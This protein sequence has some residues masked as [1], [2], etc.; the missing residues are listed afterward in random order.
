MHPAYAQTLTDPGA[1]GNTLLNNAIGNGGITGVFVNTL[2]SPQDVFSVGKDF[3]KDVS[4]L[5]VHIQEIAPNLP[6]GTRNVME[7]FQS[8]NSQII[9][10]ISHLQKAA[11]IANAS[12][13]ERKQ[14]LWDGA[15]SQYAGSLASAIGAA[16][17]T[18]AAAAGASAGL[19]TI[20]GVAAGAGIGAAAAI[21]FYALNSKIEWLQRP[22]TERDLG[23]RRIGNQMCRVTATTRLPRQFTCAIRS[24]RP[25]DPKSVAFSVCNDIH[26]SCTNIPDPQRVWEPEDTNPSAR[27][28]NNGGI[29]PA[30]DT[31]ETKE[32]DKS[33]AT[34]ETG[35]RLFEMANSALA[36]ADED[37]NFNK[38][39]SA[40]AAFIANGYDAQAYI[41]QELVAALVLSYMLQEIYREFSSDDDFE[42]KLYRMFDDPQTIPGRVFV[43]ELMRLHAA[44][45]EIL[46]A[47]IEAQIQSEISEMIDLQNAA[48]NVIEARE[49]EPFENQRVALLASCEAKQVALENKQIEDIVGKERET[50]NEIMRNYRSDRSELGRECRIAQA[51]INK[52]ERLSLSVR[53]SPVK[54]LQRQELINFR[55]AKKHE[56]SQ[57]LA[58]Y[59]RQSP[60]S[61][62]AQAAAENEG[63]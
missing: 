26:R 21:Y 61:L 38:T 34:D 40:T 14:M 51:E 39:M 46:E 4:D 48:L 27:T 16:T 25:D 60:K 11:E 22:A 20:A 15:Q 17:T 45:R 3:T 50:A 10:P 23:L 36:K 5:M 9:A 32:W 13:S 63:Q 47:D 59:D 44:D 28:I 42:A 29:M 41:L 6:S 49:V 62:I 37:I 43:S 54:A 33:I 53:L 8:V 52:A 18:H 12:N 1:L 57:A 56:L 7:A 31:L 58:E 30:E 55:E 19:S 35:Q 24:N 2:N